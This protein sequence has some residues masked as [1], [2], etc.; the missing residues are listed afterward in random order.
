MKK[1]WKNAVALMC[2][3]IFVLTS[4][5]PVQVFAENS[6]SDAM[7]RVTL[8]DTSLYVGDE[9]YVTIPLTI[10]ANT[11]L[12]G[13]LLEVSYPAELT[14][15][16]LSQG[17]ALS[18]LEIT[19]S[20]DEMADSSFRILWDGMD[21]ADASNG[22]LAYLSFSVPTDAAAEYEISVTVL[23]ARD[24]MIESISV[25]TQNGVIEVSELETYGVTYDL[26]GGEGEIPEQTKV[27]GETLIL[28][29]VV[30]VREGF[31]FQGWATQ[32][33]GMVTY[34][35]GDAYIDDE[36]CTLYAVW[37][38][39]VTYEVIFDANGGEN[40]PGAQTKVQD[41]DLVL[42]NGIP[43]WAGHTFNGWATERNGAPV[44][45]A[46]DSYT[47]NENVT[48]YAVWEIT[49]Y[50]VSYVAENADNCPEEQ[51]KTH[52]E[53]LFLSNVEPTRE[54]YLFMGWSTLENGDV[55][56]LPGDVYELNED[57]TLYAVFEII[58][59]APITSLKLAA[60][61]VKLHAGTTFELYDAEKVLP[62]D[63]TDTIIWSSSNETVATVDENG[64]VTAIRKGTAK[65]TAQSTL[66]SKK[67]TCTITVNPMP[68]WIE[69]TGDSAVAKGKSITLK[70]YAYYLDTDGDETKTKDIIF[71]RSLN[72][73]VVSV[74]SKGKVTGNN[75]GVATIVAYI[76]GLDLEATI[77]VSVVIPATKLKFESS[78]ATVY[79]GN[80]LNLAEK[81]TVT[82]E[83]NT[84]T[85][86]WTSS[87]E[88]VATVDPETGVVTPV[89]KGTARITAKSVG[90]KKSASVTV[91]VA[92]MPEW[93][94][95]TGDTA[96]A[97]GKSI[98]LKAYA[99]Y[100]DEDGDS[101]KTKDTVLW[102]SSDE[103]IATVTEKGKVV[104]IGAGRVT[105]VAYVDG[106]ELEAAI[107]IS[108]VIP[109]TKLK[110]ES[111]KATVYL[112]NELNLAE[113]LTVTPEDNT[114][115][116]IWTSSKPSVAT[117]DPETGVVTPVSK[118]TAKIT[119][120]SVGG[121]KSASVTVTV[122]TMPDW[123]V[124]GGSVL[125][126]PGKSVIWDVT[127][128]YTDANGNPVKTKE[129]I[130]WESA[131]SGIATVS[132]GKVKG[133]AVGETQIRAYIE[134]TNLHREITVKVVRPARGISFRTT[135]V[136]A[137][138][139]YDINLSELLQSTPIDSNDVI[140]WT[141]SNE[142]VAT[143]HDF[144]GVLTPISTGTTTITA[145]AEAGKM[146]ASCTVTVVPM[147]E[148]TES[149]PE[150]LTRSSICRKIVETFGFEPTEVVD[151][152]PFSDVDETH[153]NYEEILICKQLGIIGGF[154][155]GIFIPN[156]RITNAE[157]SKLIYN[158][159][160][161]AGWT[162]DIPEN[163]DYDKTSW[164]G[165]YA[166]LVEEL[167][168]M[169]GVDNCWHSNATTDKITSVFDTKGLVYRNRSH[170]TENPNVDT[171]LYRL[172][173]DSD[174][175]QKDAQEIRIQETP[176][177]HTNQIYCPVRSLAEIIDAQV[178]FDAETQEIIITG[179]EKVIKY[180]IGDENCVTINGTTYV[181]AENFFFELLGEDYQV[182]SGSQ[183]LMAT[184]RVE[185]A[186]S[187][188]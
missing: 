131:D 63:H 47:A 124:I 32:Q 75:A 60:T 38:T 92:P 61:K 73:D 166:W 78:K 136:T 70:A 45:Q 8:G 106:L 169:T 28:S 93:I 116:I 178:D 68:E 159:L 39:N 90:G 82:P 176:I 76:E 97:K 132:N 117:V 145:R 115:T 156:G 19:E 125:L 188:E 52:G 112:G 25:T 153:E 62:V 88:S 43:T 133:I 165:P 69:I 187:T 118:G 138:L 33:G 72:E 173:V 55:T 14:Y 91:T 51:V 119:A 48:L 95:I 161:S 162:I 29:D 186:A 10:D 21:I 54:G 139:G 83:D 158:T 1:L 170:E 137:T 6:E 130:I 58:R 111:S 66:G 104:G 144:T 94:E 87:K 3:I 172:E 105:I 155:D 149:E 79:L 86:I 13:L 84:D 35:P 182:T 100:R 27:K 109:A 101:V 30:P 185:S 114:D 157:L 108:I 12:L 80:E 183:Y 42:N 127:T 174:I 110:F 184:K 147:S 4:V 126:V 103:T 150:M 36:D 67:A 65:I 17:N 135:K 71:W 46:G 120:K 154:E 18:D 171:L 179:M 31:V 7:P 5:L 15:Q 148:G 167:G 57:V 37:K 163:A 164:Y 102:R 141:S 74:S 77:D 49:I 11:G 53:T 113:K 96:V 122:K 40:A 24:E 181:N 64:V 81:L 26:T 128:G 23:D 9:T 151:G 85:I 50:T 129:N 59:V 160:L 123:F 121:K 22:T 34:A 134:N 20:G 16:G 99:Y 98:T 146:S 175:I 152:S 56:Y 140:F 44:Y 142:D 143:I 180:T 41:V 107:E 168:L 177:L 89:S 2:T